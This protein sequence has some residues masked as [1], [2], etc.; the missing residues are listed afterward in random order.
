MYVSP[1]D[2]ECERIF[3]FDYNGCIRPHNNDAKAA[4]MIKRVNLDKYG[5]TMARKGAIEVSGLLDDELLNEEKRKEL[6]EFYTIPDENGILPPFC[7][8]IVYI[9]QNEI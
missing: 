9:L 7:D 3:E 4:S 8:S 1:L 5:L 2:P 6:I